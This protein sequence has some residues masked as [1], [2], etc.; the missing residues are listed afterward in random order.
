MSSTF[1]RH[2]WFITIWTVLLISGCTSLG[3]KT[4]QHDRFD[5]NGTIA[6]SWQEQTLLNIVKARYLDVPVFLDVAQVVGGYT[7]ESSI[8]LTGS[9]LFSTNPGSLSVGA[10]GKWTDRPTITYKPLTGAEFNRSML[11][12][13]PPAIILFMSQSG[14]SVDPLFLLAIDSIN[15]IDSTGDGNADFTRLVELLVDLQ[16]RKLFSL[17]VQQSDTDPRKA[18]VI[19]LKNQELKA[20]DRVVGAEIRSLLHLDAEQSTFQV[21]YGT[22]SYGGEDI[23]IRT[24]S[25]LEIML[26]LAK[27]VEVPEQDLAEGRATSPDTAVDRLLDDFHIHQGADRPAEAFV[28]VP[29]RGKWFWI[30]DRE[31]RS[32]LIFAITMIL[33]TQTES[34]SKEALPLITIPAG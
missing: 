20:E 12:P 30:D 31:I 5:Y 21:S 8:S 15:G 3:P 33:F 28:A 29:Y 16:K 4:I 13:I 32:K 27:R 9:D 25:M 34:D 14:W 2:L 24:R 26:M 17:R 1:A 23:A 11:V 18:V 22:K 10:N 6:R 7:L 19:V